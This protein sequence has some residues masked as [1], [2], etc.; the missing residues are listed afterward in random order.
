MWR[1]DVRFVSAAAVLGAVS[2][3]AATPTFAGEDLTQFAQPAIRTPLAGESVYFV[4]TDRYKDAD[5]S[6]NEGGG[7]WWSTGGFDPTSPAYFHG[8]DL[9]GLTGNCKQGDDGLARI[10]DM[11]F[12]RVWIT[13]PVVNRAV[14]GSSAGYHGYWFMDLSRPDPHLGTEADFAAFAECAER[15]G[16]RIIMDVVHNHTADVIK[17]RTGTSYVPV[18]ERPYRT[19]TGK[20]FD[21][22]TYA[23]RNRPLPALSVLRSFPKVAFVA[24]DL[25]GAK[26]PSILNELTR[27]H[28][29]GDIEWGSCTGEC[30]MDGDFYGLDDIMTEDAEIVT[31]LADAYGQWIERFGISGFRIDTA[32]HVDPWFYKRFLPLIQQKASASGVPDFTSFAEVWLTDP[33]QLS[34]QMRRRG[35]PS[36]LDFPFQDTVRGFVTTQ[37]TG[38]S[39]AALFAD[40]DYYTTATTNA[41]GLATF[42]GNHDMGRIGFFL[43]TQTSD[44]PTELLE[45]DLLAHE[46]LFLTRGVPVVYYGDEVGMT[47]SGDGRDQ[48]ARQDMFPTRVAEWQTEERI[49]SPPIGTGSAFEVAS[50]IQA[51]IRELNGLRTAHPALGTG[52]Q[53]TRLA[54]DA[55]FAISRFDMQARR[56]YAV[57]F[58]TSDQPEQVSI[59]TSTPSSTW[60][61]IQGSASTTDA[62]ARLTTTI[63][64]RSSVILRADQDLPTPA[65]PTVTITARPDAASGSYR[66]AANVPGTDPAEVTFLMRAPGQPWQAIG[67]DDARPFRVYVPPRAKSASPVEIAAVVT[68]STGERA[69]SAPLRTRLTALY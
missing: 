52:P 9:R 17:Y 7:P 47:G 5:P 3:V 60:T 54:T 4:M 18:E 8:G 31:A 20:S 39:L 51:R 68:S 43:T 46:L 69:A 16:V 67:T 13:P 40:D 53:A 19:A 57:A 48:R 44:S 38:R 33:V 2:L 12:E 64:P 50:P 58:N 55:V 63:P 41:Q 30:E 25:A 59:P 28:N 56:E 35:L 27:Y 10:A 61:A 15:T 23:K 42:L 65:T 49:G 29:R 34:E 26:W 21:P 14:Q 6:N 1:Q 45:R 32:K 66:V 11:G 62:S 36:V 22:F 24:D 37:A